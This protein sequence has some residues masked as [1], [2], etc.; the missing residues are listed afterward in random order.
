MQGILFVK[1]SKG[2]FDEKVRFTKNPLASIYRIGES[3]IMPRI[4]WVEKKVQAIP[5][6][7]VQVS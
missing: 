6:N 4:T 5:L 2:C 3:R 1:I 7:N